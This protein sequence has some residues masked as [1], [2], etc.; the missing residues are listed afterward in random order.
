[1]A[2]FHFYLTDIPYS[3]CS[4]LLVRLNIFRDMKDNDLKIHKKTKKW[5]NWRPYRIFPKNWN[6][7][8]KAHLS[9]TC[10]PNFN[11]IG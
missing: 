8:F 5:Q 10:V 9:A 2:I 6:I 3:L 11:K 7:Y 4:Y 1:M